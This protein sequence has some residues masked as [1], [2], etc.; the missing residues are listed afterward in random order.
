MLVWVLSTSQ[1]STLF[2]DFPSFLFFLQPHSAPRKLRGVYLALTIKS[3]LTQWLLPLPHY[4]KTLAEWLDDT[5][6]IALWLPHSHYSL[7]QSPFLFKWENWRFPTSGLSQPTQSLQASNLLSYLV[8]GHLQPCFLND[9]AML[10]LWDWGMQTSLLLYSVDPRH[11][12][13][14][15]CAV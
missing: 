13:N 14:T 3:W 15:L 1:F 9:R 5:M 7:S 4:F 10:S 6:L 11:M 8:L 2:W 12:R